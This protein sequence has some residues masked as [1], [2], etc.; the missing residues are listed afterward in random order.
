MK[1]E[2]TMK[3]N[4]VKT[5]S[6]DIINLTMLETYTVINIKAAT[7]TEAAYVALRHCSKFDYIKPWHNIET[8]VTIE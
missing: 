7:K 3:K 5:Y 8:I 1:G 2:K 6:V 4:E